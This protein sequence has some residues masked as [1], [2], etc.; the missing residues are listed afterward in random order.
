MATQNTNIPDS[1][2]PACFPTLCQPFFD[3]RIAKC[4]GVHVEKSSGNIFITESPV[5]ENGC[6]QLII[7][8]LEHAR[9]IDQFF[10]A[11][12]QTSYRLEHSDSSAWLDF[13]IYV[14]EG[15]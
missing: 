7:V 9:D 5:D 2:I 6:R 4:F 12:D 14:R 8:K 13:A 1:E 3:G 10:Q 11:L 15:E